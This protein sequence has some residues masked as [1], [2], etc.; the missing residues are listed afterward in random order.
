VPKEYRTKQRDR[1]K[2]SELGKI[3][4]SSLGIWEH[5]L[6]EKSG[7]DK[8]TRKIEGKIKKLLHPSEAK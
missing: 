5:E 1:E 8:V 7:V 4:I 2:R 3:G 6:K